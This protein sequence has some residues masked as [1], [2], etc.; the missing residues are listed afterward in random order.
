M[1]AEIYVDGK[2]MWIHDEDVDI[3]LEYTYSVDEDDGVIELYLRSYYAGSK[4]TGSILL[5]F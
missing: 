3:E 5:Q 1:G 4:A 2:Y